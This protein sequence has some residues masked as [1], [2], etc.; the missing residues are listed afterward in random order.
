MVETIVS[1]ILSTNVIV[2]FAL[3]VALAIQI[4]YVRS[5]LGRVE[6]RLRNEMNRINSVLNILDTKALKIESIE[7]K[8]SD[9]SGST[10]TLDQRLEELDTKLSEFDNV[11]ALDLKISDLLPIAKG[12]AEKL[13]TLDNKILERIMGLETKLEEL[14]RRNAR[15]GERLQR[16]DETL[17]GAFPEAEASPTD[18]LEEGGLNALSGVEEG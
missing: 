15:Q 10:L 4:Y 17:R 9:L 6:T 2:L 13:R 14:S 12:L 8:T 7:A 16:I 5:K 11:P 18:S 3:L 1:T